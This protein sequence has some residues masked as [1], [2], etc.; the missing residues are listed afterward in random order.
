MIRNVVLAKLAAGYDRSEV[1]LF[2]QGLRDLN[3]A[4]TRQLTTGTDL[5]MREGNWDLAI[6]ADFDDVEAY[7]RYDE[8]AQHNRLRARLAPFV[9]QISRAQFEIPDS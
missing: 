9:E 4:G 5:G 6:V 7:R 2:Q 1:E 8:D 3:L